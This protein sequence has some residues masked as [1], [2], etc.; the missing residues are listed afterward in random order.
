M[1][2]M[3]S[4][5]KEGLKISRRG[6][7][8]SGGLT[9]AGGLVAACEAVQKKI[10]PVAKFFDTV[11]PSAT[12]TA[13]AIA[14]QPTATAQATA[15]AK[16]VETKTPV[17]TAALGAVE[18]LGAGD[19]TPLGIVDQT[20]LQTIT[21]KMGAGVTVYLEA[22][23]P[24]GTIAQVGNDYQGTISQVPQELTVKGVKYA[25]NIS[26]TPSKVPGI[27]YLSTDGKNTPLT[28]NN[29][30]LGTGLNAAVETVFLYQTTDNP[31]Q[32]LAAIVLKNG[33]IVKG[34]SDKVKEAVAFTNEQLSEILSHKDNLGYFND[35]HW[36][37]ALQQ[38]AKPLG[39]KNA[40]EW[41]GEVNA[42]ATANFDDP[43]WLRVKGKSRSFNGHEAVKFDTPGVINAPNGAPTYIVGN[44][45]GLV[46][47]MDTNLGGI[48]NNYGGMVVSLNNDN[49]PSHWLVIAPDGFG[50]NNIA[51]FDDHNQKYVPERDVATMTHLR[52]N[53]G[54][55]LVDKPAFVIVTN[56]GI[57]MS[58]TLKAHVLISQVQAITGVDL[59]DLK[60]KYGVSTI[61]R[62]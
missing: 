22:D 53:L 7:F 39:E 36:I 25:L 51:F 47:G 17:P 61:I 58:P 43:A 23:K 3:N 11:T 2:G 55:I 42:Q 59:A 48:K 1:A 20:S 38:I 46:K 41:I 12:G 26:N 10:T 16:A 33:E 60:A 50:I 56:G 5:S 28:L 45:E 15:T 14:A 24:S 4:N 52:D 57:G 9:A 8:I 34:N 54:N 31:D 62:E 19:S 35:P 13:E 6:L 29:Q 44:I 18:V 30:W 40:F 21:E 49:D 27:S 37:E 32:V